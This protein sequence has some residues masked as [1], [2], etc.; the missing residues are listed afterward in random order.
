V[1]QGQGDVLQ[2]LEMLIEQGL[3]T[4][5]GQNVALLSNERARAKKVSMFLMPP[6]VSRST[7]REQTRVSSE[8]A[9]FRK[10]L[11][12]KPRQRWVLMKNSWIPRSD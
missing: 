3:V 4:N 7:V 11:I 2:R 1:T 5:V 10:P 12:A 6:P 8:V 9:A